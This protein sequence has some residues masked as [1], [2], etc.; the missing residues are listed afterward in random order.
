MTKDPIFEYL[1]DFV[2]AFGTIFKVIPEHS[3]LIK[4]IT[5][6]IP[7]RF[8]ANIK[9]SGKIPRK[10]YIS[11]SPSTKIIR[12]GHNKQCRLN[13]TGNLKNWINILTNKRTLM[14]AYNLGEIKMTNVR[15]QYIMR[16]VFFSEALHSFNQ[17]RMNL[18]RARNYLKILPL[19]VLRAFLKNVITIIESIP[20]KMMGVLMKMLEKIMSRID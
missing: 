15:E 9:I 4:T 1:N 6:Y 10:Y 8:Q 2:Q 7:F 20:S 11:V 3:D 18:I 16:F 5:G 12:K 19:N 14:G 13:L 17:R